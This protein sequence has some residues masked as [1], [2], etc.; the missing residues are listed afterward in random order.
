[1]ASNLDVFPTLVAAAGLE[2]LAD[3][4]GQSLLDGCREQ[5]FSAVYEND[6][7]GDRL[8]WVGVESSTAAQARECGGAT[9]GFDLAQ[10]PHALVDVG[11][12]GLDSALDTYVEQIEAAFGPVECASP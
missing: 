3:R 5:A 6:G 10:D 2:P 4:P 9:Y 8:T 12:V 1:V 11:D 7:T